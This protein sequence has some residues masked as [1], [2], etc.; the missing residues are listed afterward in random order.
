MATSSNK[1]SIVFGSS[2]HRAKTIFHLSYFLCTMI[3]LWDQSTPNC[4]RVGTT[5][6]H[7]NKI[8]SVVTCT[9]SCAD[10]GP[11][12]CHWPI[13]DHATKPLLCDWLALTRGAPATMSPAYSMQMLHNSLKRLCRCSNR[14][15][16][17]SSRIPHIPH[18]PT[19]ISYI[20]GIHGGRCSKEGGWLSWLII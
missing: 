13:L 11:L 9:Q 17:R 12:V 16:W 10:S 1:N 3:D 5:E 14:R 6:H 15:T 19:W 8:H 7:M 2:N 20:W 18:P 4:T